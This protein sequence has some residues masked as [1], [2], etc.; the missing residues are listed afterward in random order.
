MCW[1]LSHTHTLRAIKLVSVCHVQAAN[2][3]K[4]IIVTMSTTTKNVEPTPIIR[5]M[6]AP[7]FNWPV[8]TGSNEAQAKH[9]ET[10]RVRNMEIQQCILNQTT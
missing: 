9:T 7:D 4:M 3:L 8:G 6:S 10:K 1:T 2:K 5:T